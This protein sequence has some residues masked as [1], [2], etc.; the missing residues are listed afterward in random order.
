VPSRTPPSSRQRREALAP[1]DAPVLAYF[2]VG[3]QTNVFV[4]GNTFTGTNAGSI[5]LSGYSIDCSAA[6]S[7][8]LRT[9]L[10]P[11]LRKLHSH[12]VD[13]STPRDCQELEHFIGY[14]RRG[15]QVGQALP[16]VSEDEAVFSRVGQIGRQVSVRE[17][18]I[19]HSG[20]HSGIGICI[21]LWIVPTRTRSTSSGSPGHRGVS[22]ATFSKPKTAS[23]FRR[24]LLT[25][26]GNDA[27][28]DAER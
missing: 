4:A 9:K 24:R 17:P 16:L 22:G 27:G 21:S 11:A 19:G 12:H 20:G 15:L 8:R 7:L 5:T 10:L 6:P 3:V 28:G 14:Y 13:M 18:P 2:D 1:F 23:Q 25:G 26:R